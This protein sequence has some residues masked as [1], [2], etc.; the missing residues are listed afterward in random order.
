MTTYRAIGQF[1]LYWLTLE[2]GQ[3]SRFSEI[4]WPGNR[5]ESQ[6]EAAEVVTR[7]PSCLGALNLKVT[8]LPL[9]FVMETPGPRSGWLFPSLS[10]PSSILRL[11]DHWVVVMEVICL[12]LC[13]VL[14]S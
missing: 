14:I 7:E 8:P 11:H 9:C 4:C 6:E 2:P 10:D 1:G 12:M 13:T 5:K 3:E